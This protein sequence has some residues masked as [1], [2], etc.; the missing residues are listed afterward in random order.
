MSP[1]DKPHSLELH[2]IPNF[3]QNPDRHFLGFSASCCQTT[4]LH[5]REAREDLQ[6]I[7]SHWQRIRN[8]I[9]RSCHFCCNQFHLHFH[10]QG[11]PDEIRKVVVGFALLP[12][13]DGDTPQSRLIKKINRYVIQALFALPCRTRL[14]SDAALV[15]CLSRDR[16]NPGVPTLEEICINVASLHCSKTEMQHLPL[17]LR[18]TIVC[19]Q[20]ENKLLHVASDCRSRDW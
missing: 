7:I 16:I 15:A 3:A 12:V 5:P 9:E 17:L 8:L 14:E 13:P 1:S 20:K 4:H 19:Y 18:E 2:Y 11:S 6:L 10:Q